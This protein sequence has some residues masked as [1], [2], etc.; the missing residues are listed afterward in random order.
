MLSDQHMA[1]L[2]F[3]GSRLMRLGRCSQARSEDLELGEV[4]SSF[5]TFLEDGETEWTSWTCVRA[6]QSSSHS[7][8]MG[9]PDRTSKLTS[10]SA[11]HHV[12]V[13]RTKPMLEYYIQNVPVASR[14]DAL[15][16]RSRLSVLL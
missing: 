6:S 10:S 8:D 15:A 11:T 2:G 1:F 13:E 3:P 16:A 5:A 9:L 7:I 4:T 14:R 12:R